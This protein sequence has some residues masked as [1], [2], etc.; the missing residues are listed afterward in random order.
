MEQ[1]RF[2]FEQVREFGDIIGDTFR[3][4]I[5]N[6]RPFLAGFIVFVLP[7]FLLGTW[8]MIPFIDPLRDLLTDESLPSLAFMSFSSL[9]FFAGILLGSLVLYALVYAI[10]DAYQDYPGEELTIP[11]LWKYLPNA[12][13]KI[14]LVSVMFIVA[15]IIFMTVFTMIPVVFNN[16][17][18]MV[19]GMVMVLPLFI[20]FFIRFIFTPYIYV[21]ERLS[22]FDSFRQS[23]FLVHGDWW[24]TFLT[25]IVL[26]IISSMISYVFVLPAT[27][28]AGASSFLSAEAGDIL[29]SPS[30][31]AMILYGLSM[32]G[33]LFV[34]AYSILGLVIYYYSQKEKKEGTSILER[35]NRIGEDRSNDFENEGEY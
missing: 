8:A 11:V 22:V 20:Y 23:A 34:N 27:L 12:V 18:L 14:L 35:I 9:L 6:I 3:F 25:M 31:T 33:S 24:W 30:M 32:I 15:T 28:Y 19:F 2:E 1:Q 13:G 7:L 26:S 29:A 10:V 16:P 4:L 17:V 21:R 5:Q